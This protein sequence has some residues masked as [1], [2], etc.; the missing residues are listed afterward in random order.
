MASNIQKPNL[1]I[2]ENAL[3][4][5][6]LKT[7]I[8]AITLKLITEIPNMNRTNADNKSKAN[9]NIIFLKKNAKP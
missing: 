2:N 5:I 4:R 7:N 6:K 9:S 8:N 3:S 1:K